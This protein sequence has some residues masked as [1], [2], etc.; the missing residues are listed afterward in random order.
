MPRHKVS[1]SPSTGYSQRVVKATMNR[2]DLDELDADSLSHCQV[3]LSLA[4]LIRRFEFELYETTIEDVSPARDCFIAYPP[5]GSLGARVRV[6]G[7]VRD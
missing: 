4:A 5:R 7:M 6:L 2:A 1:P 3:N